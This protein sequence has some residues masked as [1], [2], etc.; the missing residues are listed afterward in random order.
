MARGERSVVSLQAA[1]AA[2]EGPPPTRTTAFRPTLG[3]LLSSLIGAIACG[4]GSDAPATGDMAADTVFLDPAVV[5]G[6]EEGDPNYLFGT[7]TSIAVDA[8]GRVYVGDRPGATV[9]VFDRDGTFLRQLARAREGPGEISG[10]PAFMTF[11]GN[12]RLYI[13]HG[14]GV[15]VFATPPGGLIPDSVVATWRAM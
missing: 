2:Y 1:S 5:I 8:E 13:R 6:L 3:W 15:T 7:I 11:D 10:Q 14:G 12:G 4:A 9:R